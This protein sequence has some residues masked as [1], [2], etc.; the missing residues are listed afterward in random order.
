MTGR[1]NR[2]ISF[3]TAISRPFPSL[4]SVPTVYHPAVRCP[5]SVPSVYR[6]TGCFLP[7]LFQSHCLTSCSHPIPTFAHK[8]YHPALHY[9][10]SYFQ[11]VYKYNQMFLLFPSCGLGMQLTDG[12][13]YATLDATTETKLLDILHV[14]FVSLTLLAESSPWSQD[15]LQSLLTER[16]S[17]RNKNKPKVVQEESRI[18]AK[19]CKSEIGSQRT[20]VSCPYW[21]TFQK[22]LPILVHPS[23]FCQIL[24]SFI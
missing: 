1:G 9:W 19:K 5:V 17:Q 4:V 14:V 10:D 21:Y 8:F 12:L 22:N 23:R 15:R 20:Y 18:C 16:I 2:V 13:S 24:Y 7:D 11:S 3:P 6:P